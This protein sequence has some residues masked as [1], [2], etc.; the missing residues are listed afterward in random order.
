MTMVDNECRVSQGGD[1]YHDNSILYSRERRAPNQINQEA[2]PEK[3]YRELIML[4]T[5]WIIE[6]TDLISHY[7]VFI[8]RTLPC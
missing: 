5:P 1:E 7:S 8:R 6:E 4:F 2:E 3:H